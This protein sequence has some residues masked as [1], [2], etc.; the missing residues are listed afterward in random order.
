MINRIVFLAML[1]IVFSCEPLVTTFDGVENAVLYEAK[2][3]T[4]APESADTIKVMTWNVRFGIGRL[5]FFGDSCGDR[6]V[7]TEG[8]VL[9]ALELIAVEIDA[10]D[11]DII[12]LQEVDRESKR[13]QY[14]DQVQWLLNH[15]GMNYAAYASMWKAQ[16]IPSDG[17]GRIDAGN[18][19]LS[20]WKIESGERIQ[21]PLRG[22]QDG[23]TQLFYLQRNV[24][25]TQIIIPDQDN[26]YAIVTH[27]T[28][29]ATDNTKQKHIDMFLAELDEL[30]S[31]NN[32]FVAGGDLNSI[33]PGAPVYDFCLTDACSGDEYHTGADGI[34]HKEGSYF[35]NFDNERDL[36]SPLYDEYN[37]AIPLSLAITGDHLTHSTE[38]SIP[39]D[40]KLDY[41]FSN[42]EVV[43]NSGQT[44][45]SAHMLSDHAP[46]TCLVTLP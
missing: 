44:H 31:E 38:S 30:N 18:A 1:F 7:F 25:K 45:Q 40:R 2:H 34:P 6:S 41:I 26:F 46:V 24:L 20:K 39:W 17:I 42:L 8:E 36:L 5:P 33:P 3:F 28:A 12:L 11:P 32:V 13:T 10:V 22:D 23:L 9:S 14:I 19:V 21:L 35:N 15:T 29:F 4:G 27:S 37:S 43:E 16:V